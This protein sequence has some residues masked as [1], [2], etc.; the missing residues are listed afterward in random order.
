MDIIFGGRQTGKTQELIRR[1]ARSGHRIVCSDRNEAQRVF[2]VAQE[3]ELGI[4]FPVTFAEFRNMVGRGTE[5]RGY[6]IDN[7]EKFIQHVCPGAVIEAIT[8]SVREPERQ[9]VP[10]G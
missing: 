3:M 8:F 4:P 6:L 10:L 5:I 1:S 2:S 9:E 7:A